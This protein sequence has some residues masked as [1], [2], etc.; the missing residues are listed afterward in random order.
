MRILHIEIRWRQR[1]ALLNALAYR[2]H[3]FT[4]HANGVSLTRERIHAQFERLL[5]KD[6]LE[7]GDTKN[8]RS[9]AKSFMH[10]WRA[11]SD[12]PDSS[13]SVVDYMARSK[14]KEPA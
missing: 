4:T 12:I 1:C 11:N 14:V 13:A 7:P 2:H 8:V 10:M 6:V 9:M 5:N 3:C